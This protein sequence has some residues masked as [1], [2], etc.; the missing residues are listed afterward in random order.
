MSEKKL[1]DLTFQ[2]IDPE[3]VEK[4]AGGGTCTAD[5]INTLIDNLQ[6]NYDTLVDFTSYVIERVAN[7]T[8]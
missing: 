4:V 6:S 3:I 7:A 1:P 8:K 5:D 2:P